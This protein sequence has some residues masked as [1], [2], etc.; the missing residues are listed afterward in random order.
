MERKI[1][2]LITVIILFGIWFFAAR[3]FQLVGGRPDFL[4][5]PFS[6]TSVFFK[7]FWHSLWKHFWISSQRVLLGI[8]AALIT[9]LPLGLLLGRH[10]TLDQYIAPAV[11]LTYPIPKIA[12]LPLILL[13]LGLGDSSKV[14]M[15]AL[16][17]FFQIL[18]T[19]RDAAR[20]IDEELVMS[21]RSLGAKPLHLLLH[22][23]LP[24]CL[25]EILTAL[26]I[27]V[28]TAIAVLFFVESFA[29]ESG[30]GFFIMDAWSRLNYKEMYA[31][32]LGLGL[33][34]TI[35]Y[36]ILDLSEKRLC[37]WIYI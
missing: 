29:T 9:A 20:A 32:I 36:E 31:G 22:V 12:F 3:Q 2:Y 16:I 1:R 10:S 37:R 28:G 26:R 17:L 21:V 27:S 30:L 5:D 15:I 35:L 19:V 6:V 8:L 4:P 25:P 24:A 33:L 11:Y 18:V 14:F 13:F 34:G 7:I 23:I